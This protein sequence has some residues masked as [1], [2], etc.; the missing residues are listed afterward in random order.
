[1]AIRLHF[2]GKPCAYCKHSRKKHVIKPGVDRVVCEGGRHCGCNGYINP[3]NKPLNY[4][5]SGLELMLENQ[6]DHLD[7]MVDID[8]YDLGEEE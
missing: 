5:E 8:E 7:R 6:F 1:M 4:S 3:D 2:G